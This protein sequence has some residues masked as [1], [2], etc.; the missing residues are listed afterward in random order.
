MA[1][2]YGTIPKRFTKEW[3][4][5]FW[6]YYKIHTIAAAFIICAVGITIYQTMTAPK[7]DLNLT[8]VGDIYLTDEDISTI[9]EELAEVIPDTDGNNEKNAGITQ[10]VFSE[11]NEDPQYTQA[12]VTKLQLEFVSDDSMLFIFSEDKARYLFENESLSGAFQPV[13]QWLAEGNEVGEEMLYTNK[14]EAYGVAIPGSAIS[15]GGYQ[16]L[17]AA[18]RTPR[19][20]DD[21]EINER[22]ES[23]IAAA[24]ALIGISENN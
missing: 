24:N 4:E 1:E 8:Y 13:S 3:W 20:N 5:Y 11:N 6:D 23:S 16:K 19:T 22:V 18:V 14:G 7:Y 17:Y 15:T 2:K 10:L 12:I 9:Q 21:E